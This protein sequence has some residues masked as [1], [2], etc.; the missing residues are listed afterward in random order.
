MKKREQ[1]TKGFTLIELLVVIAIIGVL[2]T[3]ILSSLNKAQAKARD[4]RRERDIHTIQTALENYYVDH[5]KYPTTNWVHSYKP[6]EWNSLSALLGADIP[7][8]PINEEKSASVGG[9]SYLYLG[10]MSSS[11]CKGQSYL[12]IYNKETSSNPNDGITLCNGHTYSYGD[13]FVVGVDRNGNFY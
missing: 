3:I 9:Y 8:D 13:A 6:A 11:Y 7:V 5:G 1:N 12:L 10:H 2:A 4:A